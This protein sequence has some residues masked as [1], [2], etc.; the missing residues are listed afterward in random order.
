MEDYLIFLRKEV[1]DGKQAHLAILRQDGMNVEDGYIKSD[2]F[3]IEISVGDEVLEFPVEVEE[4]FFITAI[5]RH[6]AHKSYEKFVEVA[7]SIK[8]TVVG[9]A[10]NA[11]ESNDDIGYF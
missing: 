11:N 8:D 7:N 1:E 6:E 2:K 9:A 5:W 3:V 10:I 4:V